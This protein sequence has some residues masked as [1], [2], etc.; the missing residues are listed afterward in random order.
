MNALL[1][2]VLMSSGWKWDCR[3]C[4][5]VWRAAPGARI[6]QGARVV[7]R[8]YLRLQEQ[9][10]GS[11]TGSAM[12]AHLALVRLSSTCLGQRNGWER[13]SCAH[14]VGMLPVTSM[15]T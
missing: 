12:P 5:L 4:W 2:W 6:R 9:Y 8:F 15:F 11:W 13:L 14:Y 7:P 1:S 10:G 3:N